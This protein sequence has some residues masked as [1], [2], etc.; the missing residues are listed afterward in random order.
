MAHLCTRPLEGQFAILG[1]ETAIQQV[2][3]NEE[4]WLRLTSGGNTPLLEVPA[5]KR[6]QVR[7]QAQALAFEDDFN[8]PELKKNWNT[9]RIPMNESWCSLAERP[10]WLR[11]RAGESVQ[12]L[13]E[14]HILAIRQTNKSF[15]AET[16]LEYEPSSYLQM[17]GL[18]LYL[19]ED[20]YLYAYISY[21]EGL[22]KVLRLMR[23]ERDEFTAEPV[24][25]G[26]K[27]GEAVRIA[28]EVKELTGQFMYQTS[29]DREWKLLGDPH[30]ISFL[31]GG[32][33]GNFVGIAAHDMQQFGGSSADFAHFR[34]QGKE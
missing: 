9:L 6:T 24:M 19:N 5:P 33:T 34:Y 23:C 25:I 7:K 12:S 13:F 14:H 22:G 4:G 29:E 15:C 31:S 8:G 10:G 3:W 27:A 32:F 28:V 20:N 21:E 1:R 17:S 30:N 2:Y 18:L 11:I 16:A 26:L